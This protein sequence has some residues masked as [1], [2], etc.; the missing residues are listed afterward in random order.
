MRH[1]S[2]TR[3]GG[4]RGMALLLVLVL[5]SI[6][7]LGGL[8]LA[9]LS[10]GGTFIAGNAASRQG[11]L[12]A[13]EVGV[14]SAFAAVQGLGNDDVAVTGWYFPVTQAVDSAGVP[15]GIDWSTAPSISVDPYEVRYVVER[16]CSVAPVSDANHDCLIP[17]T[18][19]SAKQ[20]RITVRV[21]MAS[22]ATTTFVQALM[23]R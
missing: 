7:I 4:Q 18:S 5:L 16:L 1:S 20:Y 21:F 2:S 19:P 17:V 23:Q 22:T 8:A 9:R 10:A 11:S 3:H 13:S 6:M 15:Q 12:Q 14:N